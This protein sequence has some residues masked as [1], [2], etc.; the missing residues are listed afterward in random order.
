MIVQNKFKK[1]T[2][3]LCGLKTLTVN[4]FYEKILKGRHMKNNKF[5]LSTF[6]K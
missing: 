1:V 6:L 3:S 5:W 2:K 4:D